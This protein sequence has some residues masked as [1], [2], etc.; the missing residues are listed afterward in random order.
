MWLFVLSNTRTTA[1][2]HFLWKKQRRAVTIS[3]LP[4][5]ELRV[6]CYIG[7]L[8]GSEKVVMGNS[9]NGWFQSFWT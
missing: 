7:L 4:E 5:V 8:Q 3:V 6:M 2:H 1:L 9:H